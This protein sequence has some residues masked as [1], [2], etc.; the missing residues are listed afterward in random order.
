MLC[1]FWKNPDFSE[2]WNC[3]VYFVWQSITS[4]AQRIN[5]ILRKT[6]RRCHVHCITYFTVWATVA[7]AEPLQICG[8]LDLIGK[9]HLEKVDKSNC[10]I[11]FDSIFTYFSLGIFWHGSTNC[12]NCWKPTSLMKLN[13]RSLN[14]GITNVCFVFWFHCWSFAAFG[15][16]AENMSL[17]F[18]CFLLYEAALPDIVNFSWCYIHA[19]ESDR[20]VSSSVSINLSL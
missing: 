2:P 14:A 20:V 9:L 19:P 7:T 4:T 16:C 3:W 5:S 13:G 11:Y 17:S 15:C 10:W 6:R 1:W 12:I 8:L 18:V